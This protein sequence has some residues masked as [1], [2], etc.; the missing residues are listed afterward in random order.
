MAFVTK[1]R[2]LETSTTTG[3]GTYTLAGAATGFQTFQG[4]VVAANDYVPYFVEDGTNWECGIGRVLAS[5]SRLERTTVLKSTNSNNAVNW[6]A[7]TRNL[8][9]GW[10]AELNTPR[11]KTKSVAGAADVTLTQD[12]QRAD[13]LI[14]TGAL[15]GNISVIVDATHWRWIVFN[16]TSGAFTL[17]VKVSGQPGVA[18]TQGK[19]KVLYCDGTDVEDGH[20]DVENAAQAWALWNGT[21]T[22][23]ITVGYNV[24]SITDNG[25][26]DYTLNWTKPFSSANYSSVTAAGGIASGNGLI[27]IYVSASTAPTASALR[28]FVTQDGGG[29]VGS[30]VARNSIAC[31]GDR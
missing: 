14:F 9:C 7:G 25:A 6:G 1:D 29:G 17:T 3:T 11:L 5:P 16:N 2:V 27:G 21:G 12:E 30:D 20:T 26:G 13:V 19:S 10:P 8:R 23:A 28:V 22:P 31:F 4:G 15:T 24:T 18:V